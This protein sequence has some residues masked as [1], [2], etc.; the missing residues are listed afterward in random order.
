MKYNNSMAETQ[1]IRHVLH[2]CMLRFL[3]E[4]RTYITHV[5]IN[6]HGC[7]FSLRLLQ[8]IHLGNGSLKLNHNND[9]VFV[10]NDDV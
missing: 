4:V 8:F 2:V 5:V 1:Q 7:F 3:R 9:S 6:T 10:K